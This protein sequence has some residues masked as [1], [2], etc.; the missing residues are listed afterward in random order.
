MENRNLRMAEQIARQVAKKGG[1]TFLVG[2]YVRDLLMGLDSKDI[3]IEVHGVRP[4][5]LE[6]ILDSLGS[7]TQMGASFGVYGLRGYDLDIAM[8]R[9]EEATGRGHKDFKIYVDPFLGTCKA[10]L[11]RDF[12]INAMMQD[13]LTKEIIDH[14]GGREDLKQHRLRHVNSRTFAED[15][16]RVLRA[17]QFAARFE[18]QVAEETVELAKT[19]DLTAL[20][21]ERVM[22]ELEKALLKAVHPSVFFRQLR[23]MNQLDCWF[24]HLSEL[25]GL[26]QPPQH[27]PEGDVWNHTM[28]VLDQAAMLRGEASNPLGLMLAALT[29][30]LGKIP[31]TETI[32]GRVHAYG[33]EIKGEPLVKAFLERITNEARLIR[34]V[35]NLTSLHMK[36]YQMASENAGRK[37]TNRMFDRAVSPE[38]LLLLARA[39]YLGREGAILQPEQEA[40]LQD[41]L[42]WYHQT[43]AKPCVMGE[44]LIRAGLKP[45]PRF[46][47]LLEYAHL[48][49]LSGVDKENALKQTLAYARE[50]MV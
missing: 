20:A 19:M 15:P 44:D 42:E 7:R 22:G 32:D 45:G 21:R 5:E 40:Y 12:T 18:F 47:Q 6:Q 38:D 9:R 2:G 46:G 17:A 35:C 33:H 39:D 10:A 31:A 8:P 49:Q 14:F 36:P 24:L 43:M 41:R 29:H 4:E 3:D 26:E 25:I 34:Y 23:Q 28:R 37:A 30:D 13:V 48:L 1:R 27:H 16:L 11:R 50:S